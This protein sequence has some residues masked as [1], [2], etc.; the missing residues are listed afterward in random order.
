MLSIGDFFYFFAN[1]S[2]FCIFLFGNWR[3]RRFRFLVLIEN[4]KDD[5]ADH[6]DIG[7]HVPTLDADHM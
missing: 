7:G 2:H 4:S 5:P 6:F 3:K 1:S